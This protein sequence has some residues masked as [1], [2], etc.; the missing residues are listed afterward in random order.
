MQTI[1]RNLRTYRDEIKGIAILWV[2]FFHAQLGLTGVVYDVQ[3]IGYGGVDLFFFLSGFGL[4]H[5]LKRSSDLGG[6]LKR[7]AERLLPAYLPFCAA[8]LAV[9]LW[10]VRPGAASAIRTIVGN[11]FMVGF[12]SGAPV[13]INWYVSALALSLLIAPVFYALI[14][15]DVH[16]RAI[17]LIAGCFLAGLAF[18]GHDAYMAVSRLPVFA[19]GMALAGWEKEKPNGKTLFV[20]L[21]VSGLAG[22]AVL[23][24]CFDRFPDLLLPYAMYWHPFLLIAPAMCAGLGWLFANCPAKILVPLRV[25]GSASFE[26]FLFNAWIEL[27]GKRHGLCSSAGEWV[28]WS[29][30]SILA[31][32]LYHLAVKRAWPQISKKTQKRG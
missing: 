10:L 28:L 11:V 30:V 2:V 29:F 12:F 7:R 23:M 17:W 5:S 1:Q 15:P 8:W 26:I 14:S 21:A 25:L 4:Y 16:K 20:L 19:A 27:L 9:M 22:L 6:Y 18:V 31:G 3:K 24:T 13:N 32:A